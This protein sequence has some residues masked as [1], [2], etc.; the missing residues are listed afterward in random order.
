MYLFRLRLLVILD[1]I[2]A[3]SSSVGSESSPVASRMDFHDL[4][5]V[6]F[7]DL[8]L[9]QFDDN[10]FTFHHLMFMIDPGG[11]LQ[12]K[13]ASMRPIRSASVTG[14]IVVSLR[15]SMFK[16]TTRLHNCIISNIARG[17]GKFV[18]MFRMLIDSATNYYSLTLRAINCN[19]AP[20]A[21][22]KTQFTVVHRPTC[23]SLTLIDDCIL[24][25]R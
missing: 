23:H 2:E 8:E 5:Q 7:L 4:P 1:D 16:L 3:I 18:Q 25:C 17:A 19:A 21:E 11:S 24:P 14:G 13:N 9:S 15:G 6:P 22:K 20:I 12:T 10:K